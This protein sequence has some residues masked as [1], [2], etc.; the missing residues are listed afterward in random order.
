MKKNV[1]NVIRLLP[2]ILILVI[3]STGCNRRGRLQTVLPGRTSMVGDEGPVSQQPRGGTTGAQSNRSGNNSD[4]NV[5]PITNGGP[6]PNPIN[7]NANGGPFTTPIPIDPS[8]IPTDTGT[9]RSE[10]EGLTPDAGKFAAQTVYFDFDRAVIKP[11]EIDKIRVVAEHLKSNATHRVQVDGHCDERGTEEYNRSLGEKRAQA[12]RE[13]LVREGVS[14][15]RVRTVSYGED[16]PVESGHSESAWS[17]NRRGEFILMTP[18][19]TL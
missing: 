18:A 5:N 1:S 8:G 4:F 17:K 15:D 9:G 7:P 11:G 12:V 19:R 2:L 6:G 10:W 14:P 3:V 13:F 16:K